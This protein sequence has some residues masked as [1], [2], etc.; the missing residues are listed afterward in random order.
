MTEEAIRSIITEKNIKSVIDKNAIVAQKGIAE[1]AETIAEIIVGANIDA[2]T[3]ATATDAQTADI[4]EHADIRTHADH[5]EVSIAVTEMPL[6]SVSVLASVQS[7]A[8][9]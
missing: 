8:E 9:S 5:A 7:S 4:T 1:H 2:V 3:E 6:T